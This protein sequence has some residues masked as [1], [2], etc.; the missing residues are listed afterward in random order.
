MIKNNRII[1]VSIIIISIFFN[2]INYSS[3]AT[4]TV[5]G[6]AND[7]RIAYIH[8]VDININDTILLK[9]NN[10]PVT[11]FKINSIHNLGYN[12]TYFGYGDVEFEGSV[13]LES[14]LVG[15]ETYYYPAG[16]FPILVPLTFEGTE[17][18]IDVFK[19]SYPELLS[20]RN[21][22]DIPVYFRS[23]PIMEEDL[24]IF[25]FSSKLNPEIENLLLDQPTNLPNVQNKLLNGSFH[26]GEF[27]IRLSYKKQTGVLF[28][29]KY[30]I[31]ANKYVDSNGINLGKVTM[32]QSIEFVIL[33]PPTFINR[34]FFT[35]NSSLLLT[36]ILI[37]LIF[38]RRN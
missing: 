19:A 34:D 25:D 11:E 31:D 35:L 38:R 14:Q 4:I 7:Y 27:D 32:E 33:I 15:G 2:S 8:S 6:P 10:L 1:F 30:R 28:E 18:W 37:I 12:Y 29:Y 22:S 13:L 20:V 17:K 16:S 21:I 3:G 36:I 9:E 24:I 5:W 23:M 26:E